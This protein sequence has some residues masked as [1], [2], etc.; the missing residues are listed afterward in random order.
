MKTSAELLGVSYGTLYGRYRDTFGYLKGGW[1]NGS[2]GAAP[3]ALPPPPPPPTATAATAPTPNRSKAASAPN[4]EVN[5]ARIFR[6]LGSGA[7]GLEKAAALLGIDP[8]VMTPY[9]LASK[10]AAAAAAPKAEAE[11]AGVDKEEEEEED[12][13]ESPLEE[14]PQGDN[15]AHE[16][17]GAN[18]GD[19][20]EDIAKVTEGK[21]ED[22][23]EIAGKDGET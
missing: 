20:Q 14:S 21:R 13:E 5:Q 16:E 9:L 19:A 6:E 8:A 7:M 18:N 23:V 12:E 11:E 4:S 22:L 1:N 17:G 15:G 10:M 3:S 2:T